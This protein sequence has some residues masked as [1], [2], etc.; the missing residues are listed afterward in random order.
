MAFFCLMRSAGYEIDSY[1]IN[2]QCIKPQ[3]VV[4]MSADQTPDQPAY[5]YSSA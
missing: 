4:Q 1:C 3:A 5:M 2:S